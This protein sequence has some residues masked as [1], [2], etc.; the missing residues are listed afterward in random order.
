M[1]RFESK[2]VCPLFLDV[3]AGIVKFAQAAVAGIFADSHKNG[4]AHG[5]GAVETSGLVGSYGG[6]TLFIGLGASR[7]AARARQ[8]KKR[9]AWGMGRTFLSFVCA[10]GQGSYGGRG[11]LPIGRRFPI[12]PRCQARVMV[13]PVKPVKLQP[14]D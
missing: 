4:D 2:P 10:G 1:L 12:C 8:G 9:I 11:R 7:R 6:A 5:I 13:L 3:G 14:F